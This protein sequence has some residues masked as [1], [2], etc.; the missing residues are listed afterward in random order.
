MYET[1]YDRLMTKEESDKF[2]RECKHEYFSYEEVDG[3]RSIN[4]CCQCGHQW[5][6][7]IDTRRGD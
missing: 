6:P 1:I 5:Y 4:T 3:H 7:K 2:L